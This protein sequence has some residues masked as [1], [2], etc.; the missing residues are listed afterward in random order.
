MLTTR[1]AHSAFGR[2]SFY[3]ASQTGACR[4]AVACAYASGHPH[5]INHRSATATQ[6]AIHITTRARMAYS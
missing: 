4:L 6:L 3:V 5:L 1:R 2:D